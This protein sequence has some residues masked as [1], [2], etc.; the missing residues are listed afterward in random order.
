MG[1]TAQRTDCD[2]LQEK[3]GMSRALSSQRTAD[4]VWILDPVLQKPVKVALTTH[5]HS[6]S[7]SRDCA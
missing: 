6:H 1:R 4:D 7:R 3:D 5:T 2:E